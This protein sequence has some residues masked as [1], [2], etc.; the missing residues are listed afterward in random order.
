MCKKLFQATVI[1]VALLMYLSFE[2]A[3]FSELGWR[4]GLVG[5]LFFTA[6][7]VAALAG[8][9]YHPPRIEGDELLDEQCNCRP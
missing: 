9:M 1:L 8:L 4:G 3:L 5:S 6:F 2:Y 7:A